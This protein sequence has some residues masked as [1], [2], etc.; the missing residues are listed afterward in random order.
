M[1]HR[2]LI[3]LLA[4]LLIA[5]SLV[6][7]NG[8]IESVEEKKDNIIDG[9][10]YVIV[11]G[12]E[13]VL[14]LTP[15]NTLNPLMTKNTSYHYFSKL[16]FEGLFE[17]DESLKPIPRL[18][19]SYEDTSNGLKITL[20]DD[21][22][23]HD[24]EKFTT[25]DVIFTL[26]AIK[27]ATDVSTYNNLISTALGAFYSTDS[28]K[29]LTFIKIDDYNLE[30]STQ[31]PFGNIKELLTFPIMP[32]HLFDSVSQTFTVEDYIPIGTGPYKFSSYEKYKSIKLVANEKYVGGEPQISS[33]IGR[34][35]ENEELFLTAFDAGQIDITPTIGVDW[36]K[37]QQNSRINIFEYVSGEYEFIGFNFT[38]EV[39][40]GVNGSKIRQA[41]NYGINRQE[42]IQKVYLGHGTQT[43]VP[44]NPNSWLISDAANTYGY[45]NEISKEILA[46]LGYIDGDGDGILEN[47]DGKLSF[48]LITNPSNIYRLK[49]AQMIREDLSEIGIEVMLDFNS[50][51][52]EDISL[53]EVEN[54]WS[55]LNSR[56]F[57][58]Q[59]DMAILGWQ[60]SVIP[61]LSSLFHS[62][63]HINKNFIKYSNLDLDNLLTRVN[64][65]Y[66]ENDKLNNYAS[67]QEFL[68]SELPY[69]SLLYKNKSLLVN[70][71]IRGELS[72]TY[73]N[74]YNGLEKCFLAFD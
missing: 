2:F 40:S 31:E 67:L 47:Q 19:S 66:S 15:F 18:V 32:S 30:I 6:G 68:V 9:L 4:S 69:I 62:S 41:I 74:P 55:E 70:K 16:I 45:S 17:F 50:E 63:Q 39:F 38:N 37:Y 33:I 60:M 54:E 34:V 27:I 61:E 5:S 48:K 10:E 59:Y 22:Y 25:D 13:V 51:Y 1:K 43:D 8:E 53:D 57:S 7:C 58:G 14:P 26:N 49:T 12:G 56:L 44:L 11:E 35:L 64:T 20:R 36:D 71:D 23:W 42:I 65:S 28:I 21:I 73:F 24:G 52:N 3:I 46:S 72:P 29:Y